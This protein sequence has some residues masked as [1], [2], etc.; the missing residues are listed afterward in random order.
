[1]SIDCAFDAI[2]DLCRRVRSMPI[3]RKRDVE[4][5]EFNE[6]LDP[7][8][9]PGMEKIKVARLADFDEVFSAFLILLEVRARWEGKCIRHTNLLSL[10]AWSPHISG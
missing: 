8:P 10:N 9:D 5:I 2:A 4:I 3:A 1:M 7:L 6:L